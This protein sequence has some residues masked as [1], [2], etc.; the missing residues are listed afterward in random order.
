MSR[1][2]F[3]QRTI[4]IA[5]GDYTPTKDEPKIWFES[6]RSF[7]QILSDDNRMLL[8]VIEEKNPKSLRELVDLTGRNKS[9]LSRTLHTMAGYG[10]I[11]LIKQPARE[12]VPTV[13]ANRFNLE[14][15]A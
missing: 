8:R 6:L 15:C 5:K 3:K 13:K 7:A 9:N 1:E 14:L 4:A 2:A 10:I 11:D 12:V